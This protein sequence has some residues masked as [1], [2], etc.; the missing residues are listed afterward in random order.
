MEEKVRLVVELDKAT[1][2][3]AGYF[4]NIQ[5]TDELWNKMIA[6]PIPFPMELMEDERK[7]M[8]VS[9]AMVAIGLTLKKMEDNQ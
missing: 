7:V 1:V 3:G 6:E 9:M 2:Q 5:L 8:E 4:G